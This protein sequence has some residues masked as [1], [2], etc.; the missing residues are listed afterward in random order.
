MVA[1]SLSDWQGIIALVNKAKSTLIHEGMPN[2]GKV[3]AL[4]TRPI[5]VPARS[6]IMISG[7][8]RQTEKGTAFWALYEPESDLL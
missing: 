8:V 6:A 4:G 1:G 3:R 2:L 5:L 7:S